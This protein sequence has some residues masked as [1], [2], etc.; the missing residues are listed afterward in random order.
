MGVFG[1]KEVKIKMVQELIELTDNT[2]LKITVAKWLLP[3][4]Q[5]I[6]DEGLTP[7]YIVPFTEEDEKNNRDPQMDKAV[8]LLLKNKN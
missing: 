1:N 3:D 6:P 5:P 2:S 4:G 8:E 7:D